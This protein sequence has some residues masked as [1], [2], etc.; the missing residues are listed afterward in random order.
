MSI[1][2]KSPPNHRTKVGHDR[3][4]RTR[5]KLLKGALVV[6]AQHGI[7][8]KVIDL[9]IKE[10]G[11]ARGTFYNYFRTN[12]D[13]FFEV[14]K[15]VSN[16]IIR[17]VELLVNQQSDPA[18]RVACGVSTVVKLAMAYPVFA[19]FVA[20][21]GPP[22]ISAGN[23]VTEAVFRDIREGIASGRFTVTD[24][25]LA[26]GLILGP[27]IMAFHAVLSGEVSASYPQNL[28]QAILQSLGVSKAAARKC[29]ELKFGNITIADDSLFSL[30]TVDTRQ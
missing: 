4:E 6:F 2:S 17:I 10:S 11:V 18:A 25:K 5:A 28:A 29:A 23:L 8:A 27:V 9:V 1:A 15:E 19:Q 13:L 12:E 21:G 22:A 14:A 26:Y 30:K 7:E 24:E 20:R 3:R 16:E